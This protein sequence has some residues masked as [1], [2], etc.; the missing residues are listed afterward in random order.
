MKKFVQLAG[1]I[2]G[3][4][5]LLIVVFFIYCAISAPSIDPHHIY[6]AI[7][8]PSTLYDDKG[9][10][11]DRV[12]GDEDR[13]LVDYEEIPEDLINAFVAIEDKTFWKHHG[14]NITRIFGAIIES[15]SGDK[16]ISGTSTITQQL[17]RNVYMPNI[18][19]ERSL[20]RKFTE[21]YYSLEIERTLSKEEIMEAYLNTIYLGYGKYGIGSASRAYFSLEPGKLGIVEC[22]AL[23]ALPQSPSTYALLTNDKYSGGKEIADG[24]YTN[25]IS[26]D[27]RKLV[28]ELE[29]EQGYITDQQYKYASN[30]NLEDFINPDLSS[31]N[32]NTTYF[33]D[34]VVSSVQSD[35]Q[36][37]LNMSESE[38]ANMIYCGGLDIHTTLNQSAQKT[39]IKEFK[40]D[41]NYPESY[42]GEK[43]Q[44][45]MV[46]TDVSTG[47]IKAMVGGRN[48]SGRMLFNRAINPRQPGSSIKPLSV[49][50]AALQ[51]SYELEQ[52][53]KKFHYR[54]YGT[55]F[56]GAQYWGNYIT[57]GSTVI[58]EI[59]V[60]EGKIWPVNSNGAYTGEQTLRTAMQNSINTC[61]VKIQQQV[62][63]DY[64]LYMLEK[65][66][67]SNIVKT[68]E[69]V[70]DYNPAALAVGGM[71]KGVTP[72]EAAL[73]YAVFANGGRRYNPI[74][75]TDVCD[76]DGNTVITSESEYEQVLD[77]GVAWI[78]NSMLQDV[79]K[80][81]TGTSARIPGINV[82][83][84]TGT[85]QNKSDIWFDGCTPSYSAA[86]WI[87]TDH[88]TEMSSMSGPAAAL[89]G[90][91]MKQIPG[92][93]KG[94]YPSKPSNIVEKNGEFYTKGTA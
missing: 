54:N 80:Y 12:H 26:A 79:V 83:G 61:A 92:A 63:N 51:K 40:N 10:V 41:S 20:R 77:P 11:I 22:A 4:A 84:K 21:M 30:K 91:I 47:A 88:N 64:S 8:R 43:I 56:Q 82:C 90:K 65:Y 14:L 33:T 67:I 15:I 3:S 59:M 68:S 46:I 50:S 55:D 60:R 66:G 6:D 23:A 81:G 29:K 53:G 7:E 44:S 25:D 74:C 71:A 89:W 45:A 19:S 34:Y 69:G 2:L 36:E 75:Y 57:A 62:G 73:A 76:S 86:L 52:A 16:Q 31:S 9:E 39:I 35:L 38:A 72:L 87:G 37:E 17:A 78:M 94:K 5:T 32:A 18:K 48:S 28:L 70:S 58:D 24:L 1:I 13:I 27:R 42:S 85:T 93:R 49:Y